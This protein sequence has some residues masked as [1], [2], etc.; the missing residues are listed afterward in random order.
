MSKTPVLFEAVDRHK[1]YHKFHRSVASN[2]LSDMDKMPGVWEQQSDGSFSRAFN[3]DV[4]KDEFQVDDP[5]FKSSE[6]VDQQISLEDKRLLNRR[7]SLPND[8]DYDA[9]AA[10]DP[11]NFKAKP[12]RKDV[13]IEKTPQEPQSGTSNLIK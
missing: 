8:T 11:L 5:K 12:C 2:A 10:D 13:F 9:V 7:Y 1:P 4:T 3:P 6:L